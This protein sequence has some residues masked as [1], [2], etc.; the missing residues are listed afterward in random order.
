MQAA[1]HR[2]MFCFCYWPCALLCWLFGKKRIVEAAESKAIG[3]FP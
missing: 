2:F 1:L 3:S